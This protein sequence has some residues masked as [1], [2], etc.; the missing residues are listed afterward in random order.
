MA[1]VRLKEPAKAKKRTVDSKCTEGTYVEV[2]GAGGHTVITDEPVNRGGT[3]K[4]AAP[5]TYLTAS[6]AACQTVQIVKVAEAMRFAH[7]AININC[8]TTTDNIKG[9]LENKP[10]M[11]FCAAEMAIDFE[12]DEPGQK[13]ERL[14]AMSEDRCPV[15]RLFADAGYPPTVIWNILPM[16]K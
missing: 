1:T 15:G 4:A 6:L 3:D 16:P 2:K 5:L 8:S 9:V 12:T 11:R 14:K 13:I 10:V 7:G